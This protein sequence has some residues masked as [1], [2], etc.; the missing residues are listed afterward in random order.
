M[1]MIKR[2]LIV[3]LLLLCFATI[4]AAQTTPCYTWNSTTQ[5]YI[6]HPVCSGTTTTESS[7]VVLLNKAICDFSA[8]TTCIITMQNA[9][10]A[11]TLTLSNAVSGYLYRI[12]FIQNVTGGASAAPLPTFSPTVTWAGGSPPTIT[13]TANKRDMVEC[14]YTTAVFTGYMCRITQNY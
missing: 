6:Y 4:G 7:V 3:F 14:Y 5:T 13:V 11:W 2:L 10:T 1:M 8:G 9:S 12:W